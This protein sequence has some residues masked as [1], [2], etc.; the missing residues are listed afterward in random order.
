MPD[1]TNTVMVDGVEPSIPVKLLNYAENP[2]RVKL[3]TADDGTERF[4]VK[5]AEDA[6]LVTPSDMSIL[7]SVGYEIVGA[8]ETAPAPV[9]PVVTIPPVNPPNT[10]GQTGQ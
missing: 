5:N 3:F 9:R 2:E 10:P 6:L 1:A 7:G 8:G 4:L